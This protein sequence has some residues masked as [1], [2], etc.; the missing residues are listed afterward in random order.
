MITMQLTYDALRLTGYDEERMQTLELEREFV[1]ELAHAG[2]LIQG[3]VI[4]RRLAS[5]PGR[6]P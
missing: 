6:A 5:A 2:K 3:L 4:A 1:R